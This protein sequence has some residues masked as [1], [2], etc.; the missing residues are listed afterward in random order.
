MTFTLLR[1]VLCE[2]PPQALSS[3]REGGCDP[4]LSVTEAAGRGGDCLLLRTVSAQ[5][6][7]VSVSS[8]TPVHS[9]QG[10]AAKAADT[11]LLLE[12]TTG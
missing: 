7:C 8:T 10:K 4:S 3:P 11:R 2:V 9:D 12:E 1:A 5:P 6:A